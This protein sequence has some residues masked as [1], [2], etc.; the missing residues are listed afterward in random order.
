MAILISSIASG[1]GG[2][3]HSPIPIIMEPRAACMS[4]YAVQR[5]SSCI[6]MVHKQPVSGQIYHH[7]LYSSRLPRLASSIGISCHVCMPGLLFYCMC[8]V[9]SCESL[10]HDGCWIS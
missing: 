1:E 2:R 4:Q 6:A 3:P 7:Q 8:T 5:S 10:N 9:Y